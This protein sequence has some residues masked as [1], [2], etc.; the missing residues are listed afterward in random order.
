MIPD[1]RAPAAAGRGRTVT[2]TVA[3]PDFK[4]ARL[5]VGGACRHSLGLGPEQPATPLLSRT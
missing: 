2:V 4:L 3:R 1:A 5:R